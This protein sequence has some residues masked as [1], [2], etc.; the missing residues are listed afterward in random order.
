[1]N[2][3]NRMLSYYGRIVCIN[4]QCGETIIHFVAKNSASLSRAQ[5]IAR[6]NGATLILN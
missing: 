1:M 4:R 6:R 3:W 2:L 5:E